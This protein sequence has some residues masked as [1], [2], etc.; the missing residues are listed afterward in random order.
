MIRALE[1]LTRAL[2]L[3]FLFNSYRPFISVLSGILVSR[4]LDDILTRISN[5]SFCPY[6]KPRSH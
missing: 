2:S 4:L 3:K 6:Q 5:L 1:L